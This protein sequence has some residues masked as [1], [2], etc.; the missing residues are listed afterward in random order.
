MHS[1]C[2]RLTAGSI[3]G[4]F[5]LTAALPTA[6]AQASAPQTEKLAYS[7]MIGGLH[8][9]DAVVDL[10]QDDDSYQT[11]L[12]VTARGIAKALREFRADLSSEGGFKT[13]GNVPL[14]LPAS[15][16]RDWSGAEVDSSMVMTYDP[17]TRMTTKQERYVSRETGEEMTR[18]QLPWVKNDS[19]REREEEAK[20]QV[21]DDKKV[22]T[23]DPMAAFIAARHQVMAQGA[24]KAPVKFRVP[25]YDGQRRYDIVGTTTAPRAVTIN[26]KTYNV[27]TVNTTL[28]PVAGFSEKGEERMRDS[29]GKLLIT[30]DDRFI[31]VQVTIENEYLSGV[32]NLTADCKVTPEACAPAQQQAAGN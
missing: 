27:I 25:V 30:A 28:V 20:R 12:K 8:V 26:D 32:M 10:S 24:T 15:F 16:K 9:G 2:R 22:N 5:A 1:F 4:L 3:G 11:G 14:P 6:W 21:P 19:K 17:V 31:P 13:E 23:L 18:D 29:R 7:M